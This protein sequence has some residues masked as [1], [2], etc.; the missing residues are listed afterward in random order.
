[1]S[2]FDLLKGA[3]EINSFVSLFSDAHWVGR[4]CGGYCLCCRPQKEFMKTHGIFAIASFFDETHGYGGD[5]APF[6]NRDTNFLGQANKA[7]RH[8]A[9]GAAAMSFER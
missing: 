8:A 4:R 5:G 3:S 1:M 6:A 9:P 7:A 2:P